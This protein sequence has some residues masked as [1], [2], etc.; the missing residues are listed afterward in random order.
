MDVVLNHIIFL[1]KMTNIWM[2]LVC[3]Q[4]LVMPT[5]F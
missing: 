2:Y 3:Y 1:K 4:T 5:E